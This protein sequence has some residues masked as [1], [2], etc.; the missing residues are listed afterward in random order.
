[1]LSL[2]GGQAT[3]FKSQEAELVEMLESI[4]ACVKSGD[5]LANGFVLVLNHNQVE[6]FTT[7]V[8]YLCRATLA[9]AL[10]EI[11]KQSVLNDI[12]II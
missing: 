5:I 11:T 4:L 1:M 2:A 9:V 10:L 8:H 7:S 6:S 12:G 3:Q